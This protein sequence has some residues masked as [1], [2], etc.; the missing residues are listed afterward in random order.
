M[1]QV[2]TAITA[3]VLLYLTKKYPYEQTKDGGAQEEKRGGEVGG[4]ATA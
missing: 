2:G 1:L 4:I 3:G